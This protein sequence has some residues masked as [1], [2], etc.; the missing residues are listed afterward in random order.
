[1]II[2]NIREWMDVEPAVL[3]I[4]RPGNVLRVFP[5]EVPQ[6]QPQPK[7][8]QPACVF[9][10]V[11]GQPNGYLSGAPSTDSLRVQVDIYANTRAD[12]EAG[13]KA[14]RDALEKRGYVSYN[15]TGRDPDTRNFRWSMDVS[16]WA[17]R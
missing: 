15:F 1:M 9:T 14:I 13:A 3:A 6:D 10:L 2:P 4:F 12:A 7:D 8:G 5:E 17:Y 16:L 11:T